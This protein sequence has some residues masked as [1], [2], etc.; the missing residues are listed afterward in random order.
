MVENAG[1]QRNSKRGFH[2]STIPNAQKSGIM[3]ATSQP[4]VR[5]WLAASPEA[6]ISL[7][8]FSTLAGGGQVSPIL[9]RPWSPRTAP[10]AFTVM[11]F[12]PQTV[13]PELTTSHFSP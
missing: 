8:H 9:H 7:F 12:D 1:D 3:G 13:P 5:Q 11:R 6:I 4:R 10:P 2:Y